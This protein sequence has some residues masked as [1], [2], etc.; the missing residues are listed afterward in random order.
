MIGAEWRYLVFAEPSGDY[1]GEIALADAA[2]STVLSG[3][4]RLSGFVLD[5]QDLS[6]LRP[7]HVSIYA[8]DPAG[9][10]RG[11]GFLPP[12]DYTDRGVVI[13]CIGRA[14]YPHG[15]PWTADDRESV[16]GDPLAITRIIWQ[17]LQ[18]QPG[19]DIRMQVDTTSSPVRVGTSAEPFA[20]RWHE[21]FD[22]GRVI[23]DLATQTPFDYVER[24][25]WDATGTRLEHRLELGYPTLGSRRTDI[26]FEI[27][28]N[29]TSVPDL[30]AD[31]D[32]YASEIIMLGAGEGAARPRA[33]ASRPPTGVRRVLVETDDAEKSRTVLAARARDRLAAATGAGEITQLEVDDHPH[34]L[35]GSFGVGDE[36]RVTGHQGLVDID[37]W[38]RIVEQTESPGTGTQTLTLVEV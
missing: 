35:L 2:L 28:V 30:T 38:V 9:Q 18:D 24:T 27:G 12:V 17:H 16:N 29:A 22:L 4:N 33:A 26:S 31:E 5:G 21:T 23:D 1:L 20:L 19:G 11:G 36:I 8:E 34:A 25:E 14:G 37:R 13:D 7:W 32:D 10:I 6:I 15:M 3:A